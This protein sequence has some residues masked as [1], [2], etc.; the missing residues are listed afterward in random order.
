MQKCVQDLKTKIKKIKTCA[1]VSAN[2]ISKTGKI[3]SGQDNVAERVQNMLES[4]KPGLETF[5]ISIYMDIFVQ[6]DDDRYFWAYLDLQRSGCTVSTGNTVEMG[7][8]ELL[9]H[10]SLWQ[11]TF[12]RPMSCIFDDDFYDKIL[13]LSLLEKHPNWLFNALILS[14]VVL[15]ISLFLKF[16]V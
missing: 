8:K 1:I 4:L 5:D 12:K 2:N 6:T 15:A 16:Y 7:P 11:K 13:E 9:E 3:V 10:Y 14:T